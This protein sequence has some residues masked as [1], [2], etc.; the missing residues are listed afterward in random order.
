MSH[1]IG[2]AGQVIVEDFE[3]HR[4]GSLAGRHGPAPP[5]VS[6][7]SR[8]AALKSWS[9]R[10]GFS[11]AAAQQEFSTGQDVGAPIRFQDHGGVR[12]DDQGRAFQPITGLQSI[13]LTSRMD[14]SAGRRS[15]TP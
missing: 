12:V 14:T 7:T 1:L 13:A 15:V 9:G 3:H 5:G 11:R 4:I 10:D 8:P 2:D 6:V